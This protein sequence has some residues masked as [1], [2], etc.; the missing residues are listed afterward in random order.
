MTLQIGLAELNN[1]ALFDPDDCRRNLFV[2]ADDKNLFPSQDC[3]K[4][5]NVG[6]AS[7][8]DDD[9]VEHT[10]VRRKLLTHTPFR[11]DPA[12]DCSCSVGGRVTDYAAISRRCLAGAGTQPADR[13]G[14]PG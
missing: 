1:L 3:R 2:V 6:L 7:L 4:G 10:E 14:E 13:G 9:E 5:R 8:V 11:Y 12:R